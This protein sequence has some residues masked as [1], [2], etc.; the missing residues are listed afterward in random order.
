LVGV[1][2]GHREMDQSGALAGGL[3]PIVRTAA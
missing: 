3:E 1:G 2:W